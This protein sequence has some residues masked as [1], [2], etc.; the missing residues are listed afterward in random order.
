[1]TVEV[2]HEDYDPMVVAAAN[3]QVVRLKNGFTGRLVYW[4][5]VGNNA[6]VVVDGRHLRIAKDEIMYVV[7]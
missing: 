6:T 5:R 7:Q 3:R 2:E 1:M 4:A